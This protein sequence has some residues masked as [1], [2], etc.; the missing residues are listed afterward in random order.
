M[1]HETTLGHR[2][3]WYHPRSV[4]SSVVQRPR[5]HASV[6]VALAMLWLLPDKLSGSL[7]WAT[8]W[9]AGG[10][11]YLVLAAIVMTACG[12]DVIRRRAARQD[13]SG[14]VILVIILLAIASS[15]A[16]IIGLLNE[17]RAKSITDD[18]KTIYLALAG[19][20]ILISWCVTQVAFTF[21]YAHEH[22]AP[23]PGDKP[24]G[25]MFPEDEHPDYWDFLYFST[26]IGATSQTSD[27]MIRSKAMRRLVTLHAIVSFFFNTMVLAL[28]INIAASLV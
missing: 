2:R 22:Y 4:W 23:M 21:H 20:T 9:D 15:F 19:A 3:K 8:A 17:A 5:V 14:I 7:R 16:A 26:S 28:T 18:T 12:S 24:G 10:T 25:L 13:D 27:T 1:H 11:V 6:L